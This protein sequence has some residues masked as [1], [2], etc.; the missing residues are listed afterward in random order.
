[1][2]LLVRAK[3]GDEAALSSLLETYRNYLRLLARLHLDRN[4]QA[5]A[6]PSDLVQDTLL[7]AHRDFDQFRGQSDAELAAW[8]RSIMAH[9]GAKLARRFRSTLSRDV[10][11]ERQLTDQLDRSAQ[12]LARLVP[13]AGSSPS[14]HLLRQEAALRLADALAK[15]PDHYREALVLYHLEGLSMADVAQRL[16]RSVH[17][18][19]KLLA[20]GLIQLRTVMEDTR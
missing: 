19:Q 9:H 8:L 4:L 5:K 7:L 17:A 18:V 16:D 14:E 1:M 13:S 6:D 11:L 15:I 12:A 10:D 20:R 2:S 3:K